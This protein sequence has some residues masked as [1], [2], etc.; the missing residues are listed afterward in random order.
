MKIRGK[1]MN[2]LNN[3]TS[4]RLKVGYVLKRFPRLSETFIVNEITELERQG[5]EV[6]IF[7][8]LQPLEGIQH[9]ELVSKVKAPVFYLPQSSVIKQLPMQVGCFAKGRFKE[10]PFKKINLSPCPLSEQVIPGKDPM[11]TA[12]L[13]TQAA[14]L[15]SLTVGRGVNHMHAHFAT[16]ATTVAMLASR[17]AGI[18][19]SFT[20]H[21]KDIFHV[22]TDRSTDQDFLVDKIRESRFVAT[23][24]EYNKRYLSNLAGSDQTRKIVRLY[25]GIDLSRFTPAR[26]TSEPGLILSIGRLIEKKGF[27]HLLEA[28]QLLKNRGVEFQ[29]MII[30][31]GPDRD[32]LT[33]KIAAL[34]LGEHVTLVGAQPQ[35]QII[36]TMQRAMAMVLPCVVSESGDRDGLPTVL[37]EALAAGVPAIST[38][39][40]GIPEIIEDQVSGL[41]VPPG[42]SIRLA[43]AIEQVLIDPVLLRRLSQ[44]GRAKAEQDFNI[45]TNVALLKKM[46]LADRNDNNDQ[47]RA[48]A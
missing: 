22:Y 23:V 46:L 42:D 38:Q 37:L 11:Q 5:I 13:M 10:K 33:K 12:V 7:S 14:A 15:A 43:E 35:Q 2:V 29:C 8:L 6:E 45:S 40:V 36:E 47:R 32:L 16:D 27:T 26:W 19:F 21:A 4:P 3:E 44:K 48:V 9:N 28:C 31:E 1:K 20:A 34:G 30:G 24:S 25:N 39:V 41:L 18:P 17:L